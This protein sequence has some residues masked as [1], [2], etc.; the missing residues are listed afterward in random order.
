MCLVKQAERE[1]ADG[2]AAGE[3]PG[4]ASPSAAGGE[5]GAAAEA[6]AADGRAEAAPAE[7]EGPSAAG[8]EEEDEQE[9]SD[10]EPEPNEG[11]WCVPPRS[12]RSRARTLDHAVSSKPFGLFAV[13]LW[14]PGS[15]GH[16]HMV[17]AS[18][19][20]WFKTCTFGGWLAHM[21]L[22]VNAKHNVCISGGWLAHMCLFYTMNAE[23]HAQV[24]AAA[25]A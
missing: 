4:A 2:A 1:A 10:E 25:A 20:W 16:Q 13:A 21:C 3:Q 18:K 14:A 17:A 24:A 15:S 9:W 7:L 5:P 11:Q 8:R 12:V 23:H 6:A 19:S 22:A